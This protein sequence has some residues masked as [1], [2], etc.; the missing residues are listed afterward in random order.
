MVKKSL[1]AI[2]RHFAPTRWLTRCERWWLLLAWLVHLISLGLGVFMIAVLGH[3]SQGKSWLTAF[4]VVF[5]WFL[6]ICHELMTWDIV[7]VTALSMFITIEAIWFIASVLLTTW[8][9]CDE[10]MKT[11]YHRAVRRGWTLTP[12]VMGV[13]LLTLALVLGIERYVRMYQP[14]APMISYPT[15]ASRPVGPAATPQALADYQA[16]MKQYE[17]DLAAFT[18]AWEEYSRLMTQR[19]WWVRHAERV[20]MVVSSIIAVTAL[21]W[22]LHVLGKGIPAATARCRWPAECEGCGY[23]LVGIPPGSNCPECG[24]S[25]TYLYTTTHRPGSLWEQAF[26]QSAPMSKTNRFMKRVSAWSLTAQYALFQPTKLGQSL[27]P[28]A[29][30][31]S[32]RSY[33]LWSLVISYLAMLMGAMLSVLLMTLLADE[34]HDNIGDYID[35][36]LIMVVMQSILW[37]CLVMALMLLTGCVTGAWHTKRR[38]SNR[39]IHAG[40]AAIY[41]L[42]IV[43][44]WV[45]VFWSCMSFGWV[46]E[47]YWSHYFM[48]NTRDRLVTIWVCVLISI[49]VGAIGWFSSNTRRI[50]QGCDRSN[51]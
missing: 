43:L 44:V 50:T 5:E 29:H 20:Q 13:L 23:A 17:A 16:Q 51:V 38:N 6:R 31:S 41:A 4:A 25:G 26:H 18:K 34:Y 37:L 47:K 35:E 39:F 33:A 45:A 10:P 7:G 32:V 8:V 28:L 15:Q 49:S 30:D 21:L 48:P 9:A 36:M 24:L 27:R 12:W 46:Y 1:Q 11:S 14:Q 2:L 42:P 19:P 3:W 40:V 22:F